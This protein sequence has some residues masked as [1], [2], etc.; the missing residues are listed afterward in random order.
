M[1]RITLVAVI[2]I[3]SVL[4]LSCA[5]NFVPVEKEALTLETL[6]PGKEPWEVEWD[7]IAAEAKKERKIILYMSGGASSTRDPIMEAMKNRFGLAVEAIVGRGG[8]ISARILTERRAGIFNNDVYLGGGTTIVTE[9]KP[10]GVLDNLEPILLL[11]EV[12]E[13][14][15]WR[16]GYVPWLDK[17]RKA[18]AFSAGVLEALT[19][20]S[21]L[22][23]REEMVSYLDLLNPK[24]KGKIVMN[25]PTT[26]G[27]GLAWFAGAADIMTLDYLK[28]LALQEPLITRDQRQQ[29]DWVARGK[30]PLGIGVQQDIVEQYV[31]AGAPLELVSFKEGGYIS[32]GSGHVALINKAPHPNAARLFINW[33]LG[34]EAQTLF[35]R[36][37]MRFSQRLD[38]STDHL[39]AMTIPEPNKYYLPQW[40]EESQLARPKYMAMAQE[41]FGPLTE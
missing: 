28:R 40:T 34:K 13:G 5:P 23:K 10:A 14:R 25:D 9:L 20:N 27:R 16:T 11:P 21:A 2:F 8:E 39:P 7:R 33:L 26:T 37:E 29:A 18:I 32:G 41:I 1:K 15:Y 12:K 3:A 4:L 36:I 24:W 31:G 30:Y 17:D 6:S 19:I 22:V 35:S 38:V